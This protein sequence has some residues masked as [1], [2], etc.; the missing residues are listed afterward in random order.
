MKHDGFL[1]TCVE[2]IDTGFTL[3]EIR[4]KERMQFALVAVAHRRTSHS[5]PFRSM[6]TNE[7]YLTT[8]GMFHE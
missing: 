2:N 6:T 5:Q 3:L 8:I 7:K 4:M 1:G